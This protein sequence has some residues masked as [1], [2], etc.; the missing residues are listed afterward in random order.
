MNE[1]RIDSLF[2]RL[3]REGRPG[4]ILYLT[5]GFPNPDVTARLLPALEQA[6]ADLIELGVPFSDPIADGPTIQKASLRALEA[7]TTLRGVLSTLADARKAGLKAPV[8]LFGAYNP[9]YHYGLEAVARDAAKAGADGFLAADLPVEE[10][11]EFK[12]AAEAAGLHVVFLAAPTTPDERLRDIARQAKGFLY[13]IALKGVTGARTALDNSVG[14]Y[15][16]RVRAATGGRVPVALGFGISKPDQ[17]RALRDQCDAV[18]VGSALITTIGQAVEAG[19][20][21][22]EAASRF[23]ESLATALREPGGPSAT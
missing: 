4:L 23:T 13:C 11:A 8:V 10:A 18:V 7:G 16:A 21:P 1:N 22:V 20:D 3:R 2:D 9:F 12:A 17:V 19:S 6:G 15:L 14:P 5:A